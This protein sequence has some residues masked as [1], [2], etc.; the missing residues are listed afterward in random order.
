MYRSLCQD[1]EFVTSVGFFSHAGVGDSLIK[2]CGGGIVHYTVTRYICALPF[3]KDPYPVIQTINNPH[4][5]K[6]IVCYTLICL[7]FYQN[8]MIN[9]RLIELFETP[10]CFLIDN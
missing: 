10:S 9:N 2:T 7:L 6:D 1:Q 5:F 8:N 3:L 4:K